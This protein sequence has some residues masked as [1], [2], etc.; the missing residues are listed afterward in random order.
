MRLISGL[1]KKSMSENWHFKKLNKLIWK[2][3]SGKMRLS[4][5]LF[6]KHEWK[7][8][9]QK[10]EQT[11][12][13]IDI[14]PIMP[15]RG[16]I[17]PK[18]GQ[19]CITSKATIPPTEECLK[20]NPVQQISNSV[21]ILSI[22]HFISFNSNHSIECTEKNDA[23]RAK[24]LNCDYAVCV[25]YSKAT[26]PPTRRMLLKTIPSSRYRIPSRFYRFYTS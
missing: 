23:H 17:M 14:M 4:S 24:R 18:D 2:L 6:K 21:Q 9:F 16:S 7:L 8:A 11:D 12:L 20:N 25:H 26:I 5:G 19:S 13:K 22:L 15:K 3:P 10:V 1:F